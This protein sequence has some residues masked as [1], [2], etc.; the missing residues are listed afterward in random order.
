[1]RELERKLEDI[2]LTVDKKAEELNINGIKN[3]KNITRQLL[4]Q[5]N[6]EIR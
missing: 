5:M 3:T 2:V 4:Y 6:D 1:L